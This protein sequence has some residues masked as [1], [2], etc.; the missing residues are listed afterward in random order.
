MVVSHAPA[1]AARE[2]AEPVE[3]TA[4][5][6]PT[7]AV[8]SAPERPEP[9][10]S[11]VAPAVLD[12]AR[13]PIPAAPATATPEP[14]PVATEGAA[15]DHVIDQHGD[16][17]LNK[18]NQGVFYGNPV[19]TVNDAWNTVQQT[20]IQP[21]TNGGTDIYVA[22]RANSGYAGGY[23]G[24]RQNLNSVTIITVHGTNQ[25]ITAFPGNGT[26]LPKAP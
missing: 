25:V 22:P 20:D 21:I 3:P 13:P 26:S 11:L 16:L 15:V 4:P 6:P 19:S 2:E 10:S 18:P 23:T 1:L 24:Q 7:P 17:N 14:E 12:V 8:A 9:A 5:I